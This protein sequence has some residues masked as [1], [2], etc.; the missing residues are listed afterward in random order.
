MFRRLQK[1][2]AFTL[3]EL[4]VVIAI[5]A[6]LIGLLL[7]AVQKIREAAARMK[8]SNNLK[9]IALATHNFASA[10]GVLPPGSL[11]TMP[12]GCCGGTVDWNNCQGTGVLYHLLPYMEQDNLYRF[13]NT[14]NPYTDYH[15]INVTRPYWDSVGNHWA[16]AQT[17]IPS[18]VCPSDNPEERPNVFVMF[19]VIPGTM[20][21]WY[22]PNTPTLGRS[23]Y[24]GMAGYLGRVGVVGYDIY[25]G[26]YT[27]RSKVSL[28]Q[29]TAAD[30]TSN[31]LAFGEH[32]GDSMTSSDFSLSWMAGAMPSAWGIVEPFAWYRFGSKHTAVVLFA[33]GDGSVS[34]IR[35]TTGSNNNYRLYAAG[36]REGGQIDWSSMTN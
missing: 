32:L 7:P 23:N 1:R 33:R 24:L 12:I 26:L 28:E 19:L 31:T 8:C 21:G 6:I 15:D 22:Y 16:A 3:I 34:G 10:R 36:W 2:S 25:Q 20:Y 18:Y 14:G 17:R 35:K 4:L 30:G 5:I 27:N 13:A 11:D 29:S 9:Q